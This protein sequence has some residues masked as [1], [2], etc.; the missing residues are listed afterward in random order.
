MGHFGPLPIRIAWFGVALP[1]LTLNYF[2]QGGLLLTQPEALDSPVLRAGAVMG[3]LSLWSLLATVATVIASQSIISGAYSMTQQAIQLGF[4]PRMN[5]VHT[6]GREIGQIYVPLVNWALAAG[7]AR[8]GHRLRLLGCAG[9]RVR[10]RGFLAD[11]D[12]DADGDVRRAA[13]EAQSACRLFGERQPA[14]ARSVVFR[15]DFDQAVRRRLVPPAHRLR[16]LFPHAHLAQRARRSWTRFAW[17]SARERTDFVEHASSAIRRFAFPGPRSCSAA[18]PR[19]CRSRCRITSSAT[20]CCMKMCCSSPWRRRKRRACPDEE[21]IAVAPI[22]EGITRVEMRFGFM[23]Q[24]DV[25][26]GLARRDGARPDR[27]FRP[28]ASDLLHRSRDDHPVRAAR[29]FAAL[30]RGAVRVHAPQRPA[31]RRLFQD[32]RAR[33]SWRS[34]SSSRFDSARAQAARRLTCAGNR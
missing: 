28:L 11:G 2:G 4:L 23:E 33:K 5:I 1:A 16:H 6:A 26:S 32:S 20:T 10:H 15:L 21:R 30:A 17:R 14:R 22:A 34:A 24:P 8:R 9:R 27:A 19:A 12:H 18:W 25:P 7:D 13:L 31:S 29:G 3:A